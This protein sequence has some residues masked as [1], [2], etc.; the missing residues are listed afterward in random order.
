MTGLISV[1]EALKRLLQ[2]RLPDQSETVSLEASLGRRLAA[3]LMAHVDKPPA[4]MSAMDGYAVRLADV[5]QPNTVLTVIG[6]A[7][8]GRPFKGAVAAGTAVRIFTGAIVP[9]GADHI[10][11]QE[12]TSRDGDVVT[13]LE[14]YD[15]ARHVRHAGIDFKSDDVLV[16]PGTLLNSLHLA[17]AAAGNNATAKVQKRLRVGLL[18][19]GDELRPPGSE[20]AEGEIVNSNP[21]GL[22]GMIEHWG[23]ECITL[24]TAGDSIEAIQAHIDAANV[25]IIVPIGGASVGDHDHMQAAF[26]DRGFE[27]VFQKIAVRP[28]KPTWFSRKDNCLA[29]GLPGNPASAFVCAHLFLA[30]LLGHDWRTHLIPARLQSSLSANGP[31]EHFMRARI[32][33]DQSGALVIEPAPSQDSSLLRTFVK[34]NALIQRAPTD[35][36]RAAGDTVQAL[37]L[38]RIL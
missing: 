17:V 8:A 10:I 20:L 18:S 23:G 13:S 3:P 32:E 4:P 19:N 34:Y 30:P 15:D 28:G 6:E 1:D 22:I 14:G 11:I 31:R 9:S 37:P 16:E 21:F 36:E 7:A 26:S 12:N 2:N 38:S 33:I 5:R 25:D 35:P 24:G 27:S 29:L